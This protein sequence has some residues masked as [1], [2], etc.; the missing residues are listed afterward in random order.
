MKITP[1]DG[2]SQHAEFTQPFTDKFALPSCGGGT[3]VSF[4]EL[5]RGAWRKCSHKKIEGRKDV[6]S[7]VGSSASHGRICRRHAKR[8][9]F[10]EMS[11]RRVTARLCDLSF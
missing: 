10:A 1:A 8:R 9:S 3:G 6:R 2:M 11:E 7:F 5:I 4:V